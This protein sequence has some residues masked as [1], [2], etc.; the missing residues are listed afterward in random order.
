MKY[1]KHNTVMK[2]VPDNLEADY[3]TAGWEKMTASEIASFHEKKK[4][5]SGKNTFK[6][7][8]K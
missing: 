7:L 5:E 1:V 2:E 4:V 6:T 3:L 8:T